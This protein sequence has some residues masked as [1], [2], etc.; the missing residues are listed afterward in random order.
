MAQIKSWE[1]S[2][3]F[4]AK[5]E[6]LMP[7]RQRPAQRK[8]QRRPGGGRKPIAAT[9]GL[10][11][12]R[13]CPAH[14]MSVE[15]LAEGIGECPCDPSTFSAMAPGGFLGGVVAGGIGRVRRDGGHSLG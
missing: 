2:D 11:R 6:P 13:L 10:F 1:V 14:R 15:S 3:E 4:W 8:Y 9:P 7:I 12:D 5:V